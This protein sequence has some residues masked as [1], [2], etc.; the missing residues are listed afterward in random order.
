MLYPAGSTGP[1]FDS[2]GVPLY[3]GGFPDG[4]IGSPEVYER[5]SRLNVSS[6]YTGIEK[7]EIGFGT[8]YYY[9]DLYKVKESKN[10]GINSF[11]SGFALITSLYI[12]KTWSKSP[13]FN[14]ISI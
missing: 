7:H 10:F 5:H 14:K 13:S 2:F 6:F 3:P 9:G 11:S 4:V 1:F 8:G 12:A